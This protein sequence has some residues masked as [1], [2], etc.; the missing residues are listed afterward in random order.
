MPTPRQQFHVDQRRIGDL[1][2]EDLV[3]GNRANAVDR[4]APRQGVECVEDQADVGVIG[5]THDFPGIAMIVEVTPPRECLEADPQPPDGGTLTQF[6]KIIRCAIDAAKRLIRRIRA[7]QHQVRAEL[8]HNVEFALR[9]R[10]RLR[11]GRLGKSLE[12]AKW[13]ENDAIEADV[14]NSPADVARRAIEGQKVVL[15][16]LDAIETGVGD[17]DKLLVE[18]AADADGCDAGLHA[19]SPSSTRR[20]RFMSLPLALRGSGSR[21]KWKASGTL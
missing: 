17:R 19:Q 14:A 12:I 15:E 8:L 11:A 13:L 9:A 2:E 16:D 1:D 6:G 7:D 4:N 18:V 10:E 20:L 5:A 21:V 3:S